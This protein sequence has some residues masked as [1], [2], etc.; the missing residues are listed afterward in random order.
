MASPAGPAPPTARDIFR[1]RYQ[2]GTNLGSIFVLERW[3]TG[4]M[5]EDDTPGS[6][7]LEAVKQSLKVSGLEAT[8]T[9]WE[10]H[11]LT[12]LTEDDFRW[13]KEVARC[14]SIR[15]PIGFFTLGPSFCLGTAFEGEPSRVYIHAWS[16]TKRVIENCRRHGIGV[17]IDFH[18]VPGGANP[19]AHSGTDSGKVELWGNSHNLAIARDCLAFIAQEV[20]YHSMS[21]VIGIQL[22]NEAIKDAPGMYQWYDEIL[23]ITSA[24]DPSLPIYISDGWNLSA[25]L[26]YAMSKNRTPGT[27][28]VNPVIVGTHRYY[29]FTESDRSQS[30]HEIISRMPGELWELNGRQGNVFDQKGAVAV[31]IGEYSCVMD[32]QT[33][34]RVDPSER[35]GLTK[36]FGHEQVKTWISK[37]AGCAFWTFKMDWMDGGDWGFKEQVNAGALPAPFWLIIS[38]EEVRSKVKEA[39]TQ[40]TR[41]RDSAASEH[42]RYWDQTAPGVQFEHWRYT[43]GWDLGFSD[44]MNFFCARAHDFLPG[45]GDGGDKIGALD[46][47]VNKRIVETNQFGLDFGCEW[48]H[49]FRKG[50]DDFYVFLGV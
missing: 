5:Y 42:T 33:W 28:P 12:A 16:I 48:E 23:A 43:H 17:L 30:P 20:T 27:G 11:W 4:S 18:A 21:G 26:D 13:L 31:Y 19:E 50:I 38:Q 36:T 45:G 25:A 6:S 44:A 24:V 32:T 47:W 10:K 37:T 29:T 39:E 1:Y 3:L 35:P 46:L 7:E 9:K 49:G 22:C 8:R 40:R 41:L 2:H 15:L 34:N 14:N